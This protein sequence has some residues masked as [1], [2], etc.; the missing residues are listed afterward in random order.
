MLVAAQ[1]FPCPLHD[2]QGNGL[3]PCQTLLYSSILIIG[4]GATILKCTGVFWQFHPWDILT[5]EKIHF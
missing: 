5:Y 4:G 1:Q 2:F 3:N